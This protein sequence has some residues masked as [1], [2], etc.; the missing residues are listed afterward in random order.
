MLRSL[1]SRIRLLPGLCFDRLLDVWYGFDRGALA[2]LAVPATVVVVVGS[3]VHFAYTDHQRARAEQQRRIDVQCLAEN[4]YHEGRGEPLEGQYAIAEVTLNRVASPRFPDSICDV[5][6][7]RRLDVLRG[8]YVGAFSWTELE[9]RRPRGRAWQRA[10]AVAAAV[11]DG[12]HQP[13]VPG[14]LYYHA[15][16]IEPGWASTRQPLKRIGEHIFY[17]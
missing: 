6:H 14:A 7:E 9:V 5:V 12:K 16:R 10:R 8:R 2:L 15:T 17:L 3:L 13:L 11:Y 1:W 4:V